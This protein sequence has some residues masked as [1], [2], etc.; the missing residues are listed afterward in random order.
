MHH[1]GANFAKTVFPGF[2]I[3]NRHGKMGYVQGEEKMA[4]IEEVVEKWDKDYSD[5][6]E[7]LM[8]IQTGG[9]EKREIQ[10]ITR[11]GEKIIQ[12]RFFNKIGKQA[13]IKFAF[14]YP[15]ELLR[16]RTCYVFTFDSD[17]RTGELTDIE[18]RFERR[19]Y[20]NFDSKEFYE[21]LEK[22]FK[23]RKIK[24]REILVSKGKINPNHLVLKIKFDL[25]SSAK[26]ICDG[27]YELINLT[28]EKHDDMKIFIK[29]AIDKMMDAIEE[30]ETCDTVKEPTKPIPDEVCDSLE[31]ENKEEILSSILEKYGIDEKDDLYEE[32]KNICILAMDIFNELRIKDEEI[33][34]L[35][36]SRYISRKIAQ[37][38]LAA[39]EGAKCEALKLYHIHDMN[40]PNEGKTLLSFL[41]IKSEES[42]LPENLPFIACFSLEVNSLNQFR[43]Y[44]KENNVEAT[45]VSMVFNPDF[46]KKDKEN[47]PLYRCV[48]VNPENEEIESISFSKTDRKNRT[49]AEAK[50]KEVKDFEAKEEVKNLFGKL[51][52]KI[53]N[54]LQSEA[55]SN[56]NINKTEL[57]KDLLIN[58]RYL[59]KDY[60][61]E[62]ERECRIINMKN[63]KE[64][65]NVEGNRLYVEICEIK[66]YVKEIY[67][68]PLTEGMEAFEIESGIKCIK[69]RHPYKSAR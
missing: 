40:D 49:A 63:K 30:A 5:K 46:F 10:P 1:N 39:P 28:Q 58:I 68:A 22:E 44:G 4:T 56:S 26:D 3:V 23:G 21:F 38:L 67:F 53:R 25:D 18:A 43:L 65:I 34:K 69:S 55:K 24:G 60:A 42:T 31:D 16:E 11:T 19:T 2:G 13:V 52:P 59:V 20:S 33:E 32:C 35:G 57:V 8:D 41:G 64:K 7:M 54:F 48:Y 12:E 51:T 27:M 9:K 6:P 62:E 37:K 47:Y 15:Y 36:V 66:D 14:N 61:F 50:E 29:S 45:G 17:R